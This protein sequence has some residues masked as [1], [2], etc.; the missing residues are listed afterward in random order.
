MRGFRV[1]T[2]WDLS[3]I[4]CFKLGIREPGMFKGKSGCVARHSYLLVSGTTRGYFVMW[5]DKFCEDWQYSVL[6]NKWN[7]QYLK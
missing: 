3:P 2:V 1:G 7:I 5:A 4:Q 6:I